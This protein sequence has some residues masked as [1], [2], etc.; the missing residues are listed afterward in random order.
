[1]RKEAKMA[2][3]AP[4]LDDRKFQDIVSEARS[5]IP[6]YCPAWTDHNLSDPGITFI[7]LFAWMV[8]ILLYRLNRV[9]EKNYIKFLELI[10]LRLLPAHP[11]KADIAFRLS[12]PQPEPVTIPKGTEVATVRTETQD[13]V[14]FT[15]DRDLKVVV[16]HM[17]HCLISRAG[18]VFHDYMPVLKAGDMMDIFQKVPEENDAF[19]VG[20]TEN[21]AGNTLQLIFEASIE[22][23]G[24]DPRNPP[25]VWEFWDGEENKW[26][27]LRLES[28]TTG[29]L[30]RDG[31]VI[32][33]VPYPCDLMEVDGK[34][35]CWVRC[36]AIKPR[37]R[38]PAYTASPRVSSVVSQCIGGTVPASHA[39]QVGNEVLG[40]SN[41]N[42]GQI[43]SLQNTPVLPR[44]KEETIE[45]EN[46][47]G[48]WETWQEVESFWASGPDDLHFACDSVS[49]EIQFGPC[50]RQPD[51]NEQQF[52]AIPPKSKR[53]RFSNYRRGGGVL[54][55]VGE[56][57]LTVLKSSIP[58]VASVTNFEAAIGGT[59]SESLDRAKLRAPEV[60]KARVRAVTADDFEYLACEASTKVARAKCL[61]PKGS[62]EKG[63]VPAGTVRVLI[64]PSIV[65]EDGMI[66]REQLL[67]PEQLRR[68]LTNYLDERR[69]LTTQL[70]VTEPDYVWVNVEAKI[71]AKTASKRLKSDIEQKLYQFINPI[72][73]GAD[74]TGWPFGRNLLTSEI[75]AL[76][77]AMPAVGYV[78]EV[79]LFPVDIE[80][81]EQGEAATILTL[82][83]GQL[84][85]SYQHKVEVT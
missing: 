49:G 3:P 67:L 26:G 14:T 16:P 58:Y 53:I 1:L 31:E 62:D 81:G 71:K 77:Q 60:L 70:V 41:G 57:T 6:R 15:T 59:E 80:T 42:P 32:L 25:L 19:Y 76:I 34:H 17:T 83:P 69:L 75:H 63:T 52:G 65:A 37:P 30:N 85:C 82:S 68:E 40:R 38:Q 4:V 13:A 44:D 24:V 54:G 18:N 64:V 5:L 47:E 22:G 50:L 55:N 72:S 61:V 84:P 23:I 35:A 51:G 46:G 33:H 10:G 39:F 11:A 8:D 29:G 45:V 43:F 79:R 7:E 9:P 20:Y 66:P 21:L 48:G 12:A 78:E 28:D 74:N 73:G 2:L 56:R 27:E 36:R